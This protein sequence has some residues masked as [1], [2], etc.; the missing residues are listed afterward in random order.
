MDKQKAPELSG[1]AEST[2]VV[3]RYCLVTRVISAPGFPEAEIPRKA[4]E[5]VLG[6]GQHTSANL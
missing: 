5:L 1:A 4:E 2:L 3:D 6:G